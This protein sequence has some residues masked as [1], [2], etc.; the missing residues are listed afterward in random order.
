MRYTAAIVIAHFIRQLL[1]RLPLIGTH[2]SPMDPTS[3][4]PPPRQGLIPQLTHAGAVPEEHLFR[5]GE[6][7]TADIGFK[8]LRSP[9]SFSSASSTLLEQALTC[10]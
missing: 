4:L 9:L 6:T 8:P 5:T 3:P 7:A 2:F 1:D 10:L